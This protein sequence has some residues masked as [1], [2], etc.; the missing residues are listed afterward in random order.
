MSANDS[1][2]FIAVIRRRIESRYRRICFVHQE[3]KK[4][5]ASLNAQK[6]KDKDAEP[7][8]KKFAGFEDFVFDHI[9]FSIYQKIDAEEFELLFDFG[10]DD[11]DDDFYRNSLKMKSAETRRLIA[12]SYVKAGAWFL[13][14][15]PSPL[16]LPVMRTLHTALEFAPLVTEQD[17]P[18][19]K[20]LAAAL[21][22]VVIRHRDGMETK[23]FRAGPAQPG[24]EPSGPPPELYATFF[25]FGKAYTVALF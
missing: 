5:D 25:P 9:D 4:L 15:N 6:D 7:S 23:L 8:G 11:Y 2:A 1:E 22:G 19:L 17:Y 10:L 20:S 16:L 3:L 24:K 21:D 12:R 13:C 14:K 18:D